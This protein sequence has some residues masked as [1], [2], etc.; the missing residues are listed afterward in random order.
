MSR[1]ATLAFFAALFTATG[2]PAQQLPGLGPNATRVE[3]DRAVPP[4]RA[5]GRVQTEFAERCTGFLLAPALVATAGHCFW[6]PKVGHYIRP[7]EIHFLLG[8]HLDAYIAHARAVRLDV[9][10]AYDPTDEAATARLDRAFVTLD[11]PVALPNGLLR[12]ATTMP[13]PGTRLMLGGYGQDRQERILADD[14]CHLLGVAAGLIRHD[15]AATRGTSGAPLL[16]EIDGQWRVIGIQIEAELA[17]I[18]GVAV[19][20]VPQ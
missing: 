6:L 10:P 17:G 16:A 14:H 3:V 18:G 13:P 19:S 9:A 15:C 2:S 4:W 20:L 5:I 12:I 11:H 8:E 1:A 7:H